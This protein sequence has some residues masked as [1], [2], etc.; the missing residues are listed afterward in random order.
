MKKT[1]KKTALSRAGNIL[2]NVL[3]MH[4]SVTP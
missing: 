4:L 3:E 2:H 1:K